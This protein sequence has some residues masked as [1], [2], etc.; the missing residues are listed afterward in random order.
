MTIPTQRIDSWVFGLLLLVS[1]LFLATGVSSLVAYALTGVVLVVICGWT[2]SHHRLVL[3]TPIFLLAGFAI[4][5]AVYL[6]HVILDPRGGTALPGTLVFIVMNVIAVFWLP[7]TLDRTA[8]FRAIARISAAL[9]L[10]GLL[11]IVRP[12]APHQISLGLITIT[13]APHSVFM[14]PVSGVWIRISPLQSVF[15]NQNFASV[16]FLAGAVTALTDVRRGLPPRRRRIGAILIAI[17]SAG[18]FLA[19]SRSAMVALAVAL[20]LYVVGEY[21]S[22]T[23]T[24]G[25]TLVGGVIGSVAGAIVVG[26]LPGPDILTTLNLTGRIDLWW[27]TI[28]V[29][30]E[31]PLVGYGQISP[32]PFIE[33]VII[34]YEAKVPHN[35]YLR[36]LFQTGL[37]G[38]LA[39]LFVVLRA[40]FSNF[41]ALRWSDAL[42]P[43]CL[44]TAII[45]I[46]G[47]ENFSLF[48][49]NSSNLIAALA[50]G[51]SAQ[52][53]FD[54]GGDTSDHMH[55]QE[56]TPSASGLP[57]D[58][59]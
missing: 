18:V 36:I 20:G 56:P 30:S 37:I 6:A 25:L 58:G 53:A 17:N 47:F 54:T 44:L 27:A 57:A 14:L 4:I 31:R 9:V 8:V 12:L 33:D 55:A 10:V 23:A 38:G 3:K 41:R 15:T 7:Q 29:T 46:M 2:L 42:V 5:W 49:I 48:G 21:G 32:V 43:F 50:L 35:A 59:E 22:I 52:T 28:Q 1:T 51:Y 26:I 19:H 39:H 24:Q 13:H 16:L 45:L 11:V 40:Y 34:G